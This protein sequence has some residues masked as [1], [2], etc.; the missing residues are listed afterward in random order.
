MSELDNLIE[1]IKA[2]AKQKAINKIDEVRVMQTMLNDKEFTVSLYDKNN[3]YIGQRSPYEN[4][5]TFVK[6]VINGA[7]GLDSKDAQH[8]AN[9]YE[10]TKRDSTFLLDNMRDFTQVYMNTGRKMNIIQNEVTEACIF[11]KPMKATTKRVPD[12]DN[13]GK[14]KEIKTSPYIKLV[15]NTKCPKYHK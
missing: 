6:N 3:G 4:S 13:P 1:E 9:A 12:K 14:T 2:N 10:F 15:A 8:L 5:R 11:T 7:T